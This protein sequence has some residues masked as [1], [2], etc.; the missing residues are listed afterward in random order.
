MATI[1]VIDVLATVRTILQDFAAVRYTNATLLG[2]FNDGQREVVL[3]RPDA[4]VAS[5]SFT[6]VAG[7]K[8]S[9][10][11]AALRLIDVTRNTNG[12]A[13]S[14][15]ARSLLDQNLPN[16]H[17]KTAGNDGIEHFVYEDTDPKNFYVFPKVDVAN[18]S[19]EI[20]Y[21]T[22]PADIAI[23]NFASATDVIGLD[24][25][26]ANCLVDYVL[27]K[28]YQIDSA[29]GNMQRAAM[30]FQAFSQ[31]LGIKTKSDAASSP[32]PLGARG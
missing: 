18:H 20:V 13:V 4:N 10:P 25:L 15:I 30:H 16:W 9:L 11:V 6:L 26:Y 22:V 24:D 23:T 3:N 8:Q 19:V 7:S 27:Y 28:A 12:Q 29:E 2:F 1:K 14:P 31:S 5:A 21:S 32:R 17:E